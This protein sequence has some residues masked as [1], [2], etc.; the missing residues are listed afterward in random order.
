VKY[1]FTIIIKGNDE[2]KEKINKGIE[3]NPK[4]HHQLIMAFGSAIMT[5]FNLTDK[6]DITIE[7]FKA[8][9][10]VEKELQKPTENQPKRKSVWERITGKKRE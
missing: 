10:M 1:H 5:A 4:I 8:G 9:L 6:D 3:G 7:S 2:L